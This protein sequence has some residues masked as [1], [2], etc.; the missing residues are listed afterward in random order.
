VTE[1]FD[2]VPEL[3][4]GGMVPGKYK[5]RFVQEVDR[6]ILSGS[7]EKGLMVILLLEG[8]ARHAY[9]SPTTKRPFSAMCVGTFLGDDERAVVFPVS[10]EKLSGTFEISLIIDERK[11]D[12]GVTLII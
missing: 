5:I 9:F 2:T 12:T 11:Y 3:E 7:F 8:A 10:L 6:L 4:H 1:E